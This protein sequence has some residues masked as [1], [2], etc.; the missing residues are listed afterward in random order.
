VCLTGRKEGRSIVELPYTLPQ[1]FTLFILLKER[2]IDVW[3]KKLAWL[4]DR[5]GTALVI[6]H[7]DYMCFSGKPRF[8][9]YPVDLYR[10]LLRHVA[11]CY[12]GQVWAALPRELAEFWHSRGERREQVEAP[13]EVREPAVVP[14]PFPQ[15]G[16]NP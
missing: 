1:D 10:E 9:E 4:A 5:G 2:N 15:G 7:P 11:T 14:A 16:P 13:Q 8:E 6:T 3:K 12:Q